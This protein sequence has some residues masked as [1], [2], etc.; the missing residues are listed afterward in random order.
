[1]CPKLR[2][3]I[4]NALLIS[5]A[6]ASTAVLAEPQSTANTSEIAEVVIVTGSFIRGT[7]EDAALP[8]DVL[9]NEDLTKQGSPS[10]PDLIKSI[11]AVQGVMGESNQFGAGQSTGSSNVNLRG[12]GATRT[13]VLLNGRRLASN[14]ATGVGV[15]TNL[16]PLAAIGRIEVLKDGAAAT[17]G[18]DAIGGVV[19]FI[20]KENL[21]G[22]LI[23]GS[24]SYIDGGD[25]DYGAN[26]AYGW[27]G[28]SS[29]LLLAGGYR[30]RSEVS[31]LER[32][33]AVRSITDNPQGGW[34]SFGNP[35]TYLAGGTNRFVDP[36]CAA[37][38]VPTG[39]GT[40]SPGCSFQYIVF[41]N[42]VEDED[43]YQAFAKYDLDISDSVSFYAEAMYGAHNVEGENSSPSY[44]P[45]QGPGPSATNPSN[46][47][48]YLIP[49]TNPGVVNLLA[50]TSLT[51]AQRDA[52]MAT[53]I[54]A[55]N[56]LFWRPFANGGN[57]LTGEG[58][59]DQRNFDSWRASMG[60]DGQAG[61]SMSW[62]TSVTYSETGSDISTPDIVVAKMDRALRGLGGENCTGTT[63]GANGCLW[64]N[65]FS[66]SYSGNPMTGAVNPFYVAGGENSREVVEYM[67][68]DYGYEST[69]KLLVVD[70]VLSGEMGW[71]LPG[72]AVGWAFGAQYR[73][74]N[75]ERE[76]NDISNIGVNPCAQ[77]PITGTV[78]CTAPGANPGPNGALSF[79]GPL[80][81]L[82]LKQD[83]YAV[84]GEMN[85]PITDS[86]QTQLAVRYEDYGGNVGSTTNP[87][88][89]A[90]WQ[91]FDALALRG[92]IGTTFRA[93]PETLLAPGYTTTLTFTSAVSGYRPYDTYGNPD[94]EPE[95][96]DTFNF[97]F[98]VQAGGFNATVDYWMFKFE[99]PLDNEPGPSIVA[100]VFPTG[101]PNRCADPAY[102]G[103]V[104]RMT[105]AGGVCSATNLLRTRAY[106]IN[107]PD[108]DISG[109]DASANYVF[110]VGPGDMTLGIDGTYNLEFETDDLVIEGVVIEAAG[111]RVGTRGTSSGT[112]P[113]WKASA[114]IDYGTDMHNI[115]W[116]TRYV[117]GVED[118]VS[119]SRAAIFAT[120]PVG[121]EV[122]SFISSDLSYRLNLPSQVTIGA[123]VFNVFDEEP[124]FARLDLSYDPFIGNPLGRYYKVSLSKQF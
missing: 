105:F 4:R 72:G 107:G 11:P 56:G 45:T 117:D 94:L 85:L 21:D 14:P 65:P 112:L 96:A 108:V 62:S 33:W 91:V 69:N 58:K 41:D 64:F 110:Q 35:G 106:N 44:G 111:D 102:A 13:L 57:P 95:T 90:R 71:K 28:E 42:I 17:Y 97:G 75:F 104:A 88:I 122:D 79:F 32:D 55:T 87:K 48:T 119:P 68:G 86:F 7:A 82:D 38:G 27:S 9:T 93:P 49:R 15:D 116:T 8:V 98:I 115:R 121:R 60:L 99:D 43:H 81:N 50:G 25:G 51:Q 39:V 59:Q 84:F 47:P 53:G 123:S 66:S 3:G 113:Q 5:G 101:V 37:L 76:V 36:A 18:S 114:Y 30:H 67:F 118:G 83:V 70:A 61:D 26:V 77:T 92:S 10:M 124:P 109:L 103:L 12:L 29:S 1:M 23:D 120:N 40:A 54:V 19:N 6:V 78:S 63:P 52:I 46:A 16:L 22:L 20:T 100:S 24:Y 31:T 89:A 80:A 2:S 73:D 74:S 34:S